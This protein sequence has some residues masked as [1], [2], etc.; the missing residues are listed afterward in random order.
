[1]RAVAIILNL[2]REDFFRTSR[3]L[4][5]VSGEGGVGGSFLCLIAL[6]KQTVEKMLFNSLG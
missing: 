6:F 5:D 4:T 2:S 3:M 1:M